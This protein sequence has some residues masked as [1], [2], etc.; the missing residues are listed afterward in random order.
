MDLKE[1]FSYM[2]V[3]R[4]PVQPIPVDFPPANPRAPSTPGMEHRASGK[5][6]KYEPHLTSESAL[7]RV[8][9]AVKR[10][11]DKGNSYPRQISTGLA[12]RFR[13][14]VCYN[15]DRNHDSIQMQKN[16]VNRTSTEIRIS[17]VP[18]DEA[19]RSSIFHY[20]PTCPLQ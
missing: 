3:L 8:S 10:N 12:Y 6:M 20:P 19:L 14:S 4:H 9:I 5:D 17:N 15:H 18:Q 11:Q 13:D 7:V 2:C 1:I 16:V